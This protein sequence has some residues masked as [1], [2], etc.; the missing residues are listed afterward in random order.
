M[1]DVEVVVIGAG[2]AGLAAALNLARAA[3]SVV[4][5]DSNRPRHAVSLKSHGFITRDGVP[6]LELRRLGREEIE[7]YDEVTVVTANVTQVVS[8]ETGVFVTAASRSGEQYQYRAAHV[9]VASGLT[10]SFPQIPSLR[11]F[12]GTSIHSCMEC[13]AYEYKGAAIGLI[14]ET[15]DVAERAL[16][17]SQWSS[18][19]VVFTNGVDCVSEWW[20]GRLGEAGIAVDRRPIQDIEGGQGGFITGVRFTDQDFL[21]RRALFVRPQWTANLQFAAPLQLVTDADGLVTVDHL[22]RTSAH[23][24]WAVGDI[25]PPGPQQLMIAAGAGQRVA[26]AINRSLVGLG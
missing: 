1:I 21:E 25:T 7:A 13:D 18:D 6:P 24:V 15:E 26:A 19:V 23:G 2:P 10:E 12:Y 5:V 9:V 3:R 14:G 16:L 17:L 11:Q 8:D 20:A 4:V 22:G